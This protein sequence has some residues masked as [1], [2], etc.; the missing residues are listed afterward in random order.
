MTKDPKGQ[1]KAEG[2]G[3]KEI[4]VWKTEEWK[5]G[6]EETN[7]M[8]RGEKD[9]ETKGMGGMEGRKESKADGMKRKGHALVQKTGRTFIS[10]TTW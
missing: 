1:T 2:K 10:T 9:G 3:G 8:R 7:L 6:G 4:K 5:T